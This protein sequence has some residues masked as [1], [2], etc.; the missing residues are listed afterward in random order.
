ML[1]LTLATAWSPG[2]SANPAVPMYAAGAA[3]YVLDPAQNDRNAPP[4]RIRSTTGDALTA[5]FGSLLLR[6]TNIFARQ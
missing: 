2:G 1:I 5:S 6:Q 3:T 4:P